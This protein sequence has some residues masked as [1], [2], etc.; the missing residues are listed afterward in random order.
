MQRLSCL[1]V[2]LGAVQASASAVTPTQKVIQLMTKMVDKGEAEMDA[3]QVQFKKYVKFCENTT[4]E[5]GRRIEEATEKVEQ[6]TTSIEKAAAEID[7]LNTEI[8]HQQHIIDHDSEELENATA[9]RDEENKD[10]L[11]NLKDLEDSDAAMVRAMSVLKGAAKSHEQVALLQTQLST[12]LDS[13]HMNPGQA[14]QYLNDFLRDAEDDAAPKQTLKSFLEESED[15]LVIEAPKAQ[16]YNRHSGG[17]IELMEK[18]QAEFRAEMGKIKSEELQKKN[19][20]LGLKAGFD[21]EI[22]DATS[23]K[24]TA[25]KNMNSIAQEKAENEADLAETEDVLAADTKYKKD[26]EMDWA[27]QGADY[28]ARQQLRGEE[29]EAINKAISIINGSSVS[30]SADKH[31]PG[32]LQVNDAVAL[33]Q[34][35]SSNLRGHNLVQRAAQLLQKEA[36]ELQSNELAALALR[37]SSG[38]PIDKI[39]SMIEDMVANIKSKMDAE[40]T[41]EAWCEEEVAKNKE[42]RGELSDEVEEL[43]SQIEKLEASIKTTSHD[44]SDLSASLTETKQAM[45]EATEL[46]H[47]EKA[48]NTVTIADAK[49]AQAAVD[50]ALKVLQDF[51]EKAGK[52][53]ALTQLSSQGLAN[54]EAP[55]ALSGGTYNG[56]GSETGGVLGL[57]EV[58]KSDFARLEAETT[59]EEETAASEYETF[60]EDSHLDVTK[61]EK[62]VQYKTMNKESKERKLASENMDLEGVQAELDAATKTF[63]ELKPQCATHHPTFEERKA[64]RDKKIKALEDSLEALRSSE[65]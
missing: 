61:K 23:R 50:Q 25:T 62:D 22:T 1:F 15:P 48:N 24:G 47:E 3:E 35:S 7:E 57:I 38:G 9:V 44:I 34:M 49:A 11:Q 5:K 6:L 43:Q 54:P 55:Q 33:A 40:A 18:L 28:K 8:E 29:L 21:A 12:V 59:S 63:E 60:M 17:V 14:S 45:S 19:A 65:A 10:Y 42:T 20:Y 27:K 56:M 26:L 4:V 58:I 2:L 32:L 39:K 52:A 64:E 13:S 53:T 31:L 16:G 30:G 51:Y 37:M 36:Q 46:R 41:K